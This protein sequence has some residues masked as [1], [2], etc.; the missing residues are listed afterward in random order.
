[1]T[2]LGSKESI[3][4]GVMQE[5][6]QLA[7]IMGIDFFGNLSRDYYTMAK[8]FDPEIAEKFDHPI[9]VKIYYI[10]S[11]LEPTVMTTGLK[12]V[13]DFTYDTCPRDLDIVFIPGT[14]PLQRPPQA[15]RFMKEAFPKTRVW[16][17][18]CLGSLWL[19]SA[20]VL[21]GKKCTTNREFLKMAGEVHPDTEWLSQRWVVEDKEYE[22]EG[23][24]EL[25]T[26]GGAGAGL[27]MIITYLNQNFDQAFVNKFVVQAL[28]LEELG[29]SQFYKTSR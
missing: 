9:D 18:T 22:G 17:T 29:S 20:G 25:W 26:S 24:G 21:K 11:T 12:F 16:M 14:S 6:A 28:G 8:D 7:D 3:R 19:A 4:I 15:D 1:M 5:G 23:K 10:S 13:P 27:S 2:A